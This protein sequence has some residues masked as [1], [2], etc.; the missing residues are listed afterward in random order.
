MTT[1]TPTKAA[2]VR[3]Q[4]QSQL[5]VAWAQFRKNRLAQTGGV[6][7]I[8]LYLMA[9]FAPFLAPDGLSNYSTSNI[10]RFHPPTPIQFRD[11]ETGAFT[12]P[13][14]FKYGQELNMDTFV[15]EYKPT[16]QQCPIYF[17]VRGDPYKILG[18]IPG[19]IHL[20]GT[21]AQNPDC[22]VYLLGG[23]DLGRDLLTRTLYAS[24]ISLTIGVAAVLIS[25]LIGLL[26]GAMSAYFG[27]IVDTVIMR[28][29]EV[30]A[31][32]PYLF[33]LL[34]LRSVFPKD[35]NPILALYV[36]LG[37]LA[38]IGWGGL[39]RV[40][41]GQLLSVREQDFV[42]AAKSLGA[43]DNRI[44]WRHMLPTMTTYV[45]VTTSLAIPSYI[46]L[47][48]SLSFLGVGAVEPY[49]S[50]GSLLKAAQDGGL[51]SLNTRP[52]VLAPGFFIVFT[53]M[54]FQLLGDGLRD[55][56]D[57]KKRS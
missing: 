54:C 57:P 27:G 24:Q 30:L 21:G 46:L 6:M 22:N 11:P 42:S 29:V 25:T 33:L 47:E 8:L 53:V 4:G 5:S 1:T 15:N 12:R 38:F 50:W 13:F 3:P 23:E 45:I 16:T 14:V 26:M 10:T 17:G 40:T 51:S 49:A 7:I 37:I 28:L 32:I 31:A 9:I 41:R 48:S 39:A 2:R 52:W 19:N 56:F 20:F 55:A 18:F 35:I 43:S 44:M 36:I 34:L